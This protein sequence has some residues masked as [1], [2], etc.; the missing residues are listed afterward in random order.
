MIVFEMPRIYRLL[1]GFLKC[2]CYSNLVPF[3]LHIT[4]LGGRRNVPLLVLLLEVEKVFGIGGSEIAS[5]TLYTPEN[6][7]VIGV[8]T[9]DIPL[10]VGGEPDLL[11]ILVRVLGLALFCINLKSKNKSNSI[12]I[13]DLNT[14]IRR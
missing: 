11:R 10:G 4:Y 2:P 14:S 9:G 1:L 7:G 3:L 6:A 13:L 5:S 8:A 12:S